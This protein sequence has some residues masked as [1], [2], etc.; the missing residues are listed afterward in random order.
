MG[1]NRL[2]FDIGLLLHDALKR[3]HARMLRDVLN[4]DVGCRVVREDGLDLAHAS[5]VSSEAALV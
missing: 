5:L 1:P 4:V 2:E 3:T